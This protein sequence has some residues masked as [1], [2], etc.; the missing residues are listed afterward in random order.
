MRRCLRAVIVVALLCGAG[1]ARAQFAVLDTANLAQNILTAGAD[2]RG[3]QQQQMQISSSHQM[4]EN[5]AR[6]L[7]LAELL[8]SASS[9]ARSIR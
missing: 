6:N 2:A 3:D 8:D 5:D 9:Q 4:L 1:D 7:R